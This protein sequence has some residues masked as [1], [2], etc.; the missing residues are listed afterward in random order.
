MSFCDHHTLDQNSNSETLPSTFPS[1]DGQT[2][3][4]HPSALVNFIKNYLNKIKYR[5]ILISGDSDI[6]IPDDRENE[7]NII[8]EHFL[9]IKWYSQNC[10]KP[11]G[12][13]H[14][15]PIGLCFH[16]IYTDKWST[17]QKSIDYYK[18][19]IGRLRQNEKKIKCFSNF[20][21]LT[22]T[23]Y[24]KYDRINAIKEINKELIDY[25]EKRISCEETWKLMSSYKYI[26][27]PQGNG[28]DCHRTW[29]ALVL[30]CIPIVKSSCLDPLY[31]GLPVLIVKNWV[32]I[33]SELLE[34]FKPQ[35]Y[36][37]EKLDIEYWKKE[38]KNICDN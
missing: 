4:I 8:L 9:L 37:I 36:N 29:E 28:L 31:E 1:K 35:T 5:F 30:G 38:F 24:A 33:T 7:A 14:Q 22:S 13:L 34:N 11:S 10:T 17:R 12:K 6:T 21:F 25:Q 26:I 23:R 18:N 15:L 19:L 32:D 3:Y 16:V 2:I 27:S 20:H